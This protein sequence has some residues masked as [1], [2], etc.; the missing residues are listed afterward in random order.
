MQRVYNRSKVHGKIFGFVSP[1][2]RHDSHT[3]IT[4]KRNKHLF[5]VLIIL[6]HRRSAQLLRYEDLL[7]ETC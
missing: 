7:L 5:E 3:H 6:Q 2:L 4:F 1:Q